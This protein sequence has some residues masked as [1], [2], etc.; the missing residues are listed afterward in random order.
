MNEFDKLSAAISNFLIATTQMVDAMS[1]FA[2]AVLTHKT[3]LDFVLIPAIYKV[4]EK[5]HADWVHRANFSK[6]KRIRKKYHDRII[7]KY[8]TILNR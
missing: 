2:K 1:D 8:G 6:K 7:R 5:E 4:A 3:E